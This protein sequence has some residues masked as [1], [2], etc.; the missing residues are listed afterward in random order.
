MC[1]T[2]CTDNMSCSYTS[3]SGE[4]SSYKNVSYR[5]GW[6]FVKIYSILFFGDGRSQFGKVTSGAIAQQQVFDFT[7]AAPRC[8]AAIVEQEHITRPGAAA[9][10][11]FAMYSQRE[12]VRWKSECP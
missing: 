12:V 6:M 3:A 5:A 1:R 11:G 2:R 4:E 8:A 10:R 7:C 9:V